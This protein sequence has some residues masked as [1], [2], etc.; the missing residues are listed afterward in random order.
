MG[1]NAG[2]VKHKVTICRYQAV[3]DGLNGTVNKLVSFRTRVCGDA[4]DER[5][6]V[7]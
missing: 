7:P 2:R 3:D 1:V 5:Q 6:R 4:A